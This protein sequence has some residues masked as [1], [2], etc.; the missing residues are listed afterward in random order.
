MWR[1]RSGPMPGSAARSSALARLRSIRLA[2][3]ERR[4]RAG[5]RLAGAPDRVGGGGGVGARPSEAGD[6]EGAKEEER[7]EAAF[8]HSQVSAAARQSFRGILRNV[9]FETEVDDILRELLR[10]PGTLAA[11]LGAVGGPSEEE[12]EQRLPLGAGAE[13]VVSVADGAAPALEQTLNQAARELRACIRRYGLET[14]PEVRLVGRVPRSRAALL[15]RTEALLAA[16]AAMH[17]AVGAASLR[18]PELL[19]VGGDDRHRAQASACRFCASASTRRRPS[20][21]A[22]PRTAR[23]WATT[24]SPGPSGSTLTWWCSST[25]RRA[26][27]VDFVRH[28]ARAVA[29]ELAVVM[30]HLDDDPPAPANVRPLPPVTPRRRAARAACRARSRRAARAR[31]AR[32]TCASMTQEILISEVEISWMLMFSRARI[33]N[34]FSATP[35]CERMPTPTTETLAR[36]VVGL[37]PLAPAH[38]VGALLGQELHARAHDRPRAP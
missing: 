16:F 8:V 4:R 11:R 38:E 24:S 2:E 18:G 20:S 34:I 13:L 35:A 17:G 12:G 15:K 7:D 21:A 28:R 1:A 33:S 27:S 31:R 3:E 5:R 30:P 32:R 36:F 14:V 10:A 26:W 25:S 9:A 22:R 6:G 23:S 19:A 29:R 37:D